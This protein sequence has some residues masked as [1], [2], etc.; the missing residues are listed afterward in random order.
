MKM[1][2]VVPVCH[3]RNPAK[4]N[5]SWSNDNPDRRFF[6]CK[7]FD[8]RFQKP[9]RFFSWFDPPLTP[10]SR[11]VLLGL[12]KKVRTLED[13]RKRERRTWLLVL[14]IVTVLLFLKA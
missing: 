2:E 14:V 11:I 6:G 13:A 12:L 3:C 10:H 8:S 9:C 1:P 7:K 4:L 5:M